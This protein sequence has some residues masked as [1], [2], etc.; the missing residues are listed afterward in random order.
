MPDDSLHEAPQE[1]GWNIR[2]DL[3]DVIGAAGLVL[4]LVGAAFINFGFAIFVAGTALCAVAW[5]MAR[6]V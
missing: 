4:A 2:I 1:R 5:R 6:R 3:A